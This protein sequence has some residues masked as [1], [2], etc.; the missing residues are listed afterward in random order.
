MMHRHRRATLTLVLF[1]ALALVLPFGGDLALDGATRCAWRIDHCPSSSLSLASHAAAVAL[2]PGGLRPPFGAGKGVERSPSDQHTPDGRLAAGGDR[3][4]GR[5][6]A[7]ASTG[8]HRA[9]LPLLRS[10]HAGSD[11]SLPRSPPDR[12]LSS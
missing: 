5:A 4:C 7:D 3:W 8:E 12:D 1:Y 9:A 2:Q 6:Q 11:A 10:A